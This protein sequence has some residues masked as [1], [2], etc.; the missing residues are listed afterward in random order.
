MPRRQQLI[1][2]TEGLDGLLTLEHR[3][4]IDAFMRTGDK[5]IAY[6]EIYGKK[7]SRKVAI[8]NADRLLARAEVQQELAARFKQAKLTKS[9]LI[10]KVSEIL[11]YR[12]PKFYCR[13]KVSE[14]P[15]MKAVDAA[16]LI[17]EL[18]GYIEKTPTGGNI[19]NIIVNFPPVYSEEEKKRFEQNIV[20]GNRLIE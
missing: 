19:N 6:E 13:K 15:H 8:T 12:E 4:F 9:Y 17:A 11:E 14:V 1:P 7:K 16:R 3:K 18:G 2:I 10:E 20:D 5:V